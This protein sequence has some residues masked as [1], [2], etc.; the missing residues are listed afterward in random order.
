MQE[1]TLIG[2]PKVW[3]K[4]LSHPLLNQW[5]RHI[6]SKSMYGN[7]FLPLGWDVNDLTS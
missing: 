5:V 7:S 1:T 3:D 2:F 6:I 4:M